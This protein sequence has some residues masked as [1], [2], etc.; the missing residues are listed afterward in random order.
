MPAL[1]L[2]DFS[3]RAVADAPAPSDEEDGARQAA[4]EEGYAAGWEDAASAH[5]D[6]RAER[7]AEVARHL[8]VIAL[9]Y[10]EAR[11]HVLRAMEPLLVELATRLL[12]Q[13]MRV[14]LGP[15]VLDALMPLAEMLADTPALLRIAPGARVEVESFLNAQ[16]GFPIQIVEDDSLSGGQVVLARGGTEMRV[17]LDAAIAAIVDAVRGYFEVQGVEQSN[18]G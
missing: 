12:P 16:T 6:S 7:E 11:L 5:A 2:E 14:A 15:A 4:Y 1:K 8:Q 3:Q 13:T 9:G 10:Q 18:V 17:D